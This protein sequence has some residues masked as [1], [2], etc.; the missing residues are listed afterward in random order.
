MEQRA[1]NNGDFS[2]RS[3]P[4]PIVPCT[5]YLLVDRLATGPF[6]FGW[7]IYGK[8]SGC[9]L[10]QSAQGASHIAALLEPVLGYR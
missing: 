8:Y 3:D 5:P 2:T 9:K 10:Y 6:G 4:F 1:S 7:Y